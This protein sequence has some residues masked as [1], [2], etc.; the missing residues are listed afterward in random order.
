MYGR[1]VEVEEVW[2][3]A[4]TLILCIAR[5]IHTTGYISVVMAICDTRQNLSIASV[6]PL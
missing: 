5:A 1:M 3:A 6:L 2:K 4:L